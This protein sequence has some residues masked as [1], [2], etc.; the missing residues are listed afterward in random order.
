MGRLELPIPEL[1][2]ESLSWSAKALEKRIRA[3]VPPSLRDSVTVRPFKKG[4]RTGVL[5]DY[6]DEAESHVFVAI[7]YPKG[8]A[9]NEDSVPR[10][11][12]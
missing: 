9:R 11:R 12:R 1:G 8:G 3:Q 4:E 6:P 7:E 10:R 5:I 2:N